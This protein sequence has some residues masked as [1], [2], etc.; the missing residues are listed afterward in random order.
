MLLVCGVGDNRR[1]FPIGD[2][3]WAIV[4]FLVF[5]HCQDYSAV[6]ALRRRGSL[7]GWACVR[8]RE[9]TVVILPGWSWPGDKGYGWRME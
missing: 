4:R 8:E 1:T 3:I 6:L 5:Y 7:V 9:I 2:S